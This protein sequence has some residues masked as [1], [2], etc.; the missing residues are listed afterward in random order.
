MPERHELHTHL[1]HPLLCFMECS[2][3]GGPKSRDPG[4][5][6]LEQSGVLP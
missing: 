4:S 5:M 2:Q 1:P 6:V 3:S